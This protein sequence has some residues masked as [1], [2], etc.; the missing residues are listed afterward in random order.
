MN[1]LLAF[2][3][4]F[5]VVGDPDEVSQAAVMRALHRASAK[6]AAEFGDS[7]EVAIDF[8]RDISIRMPLLF[9]RVTEQD[10][11]ARFSDLRQVRRDYT[12]LKIIY[13]HI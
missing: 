10:V 5:P 9:D 1:E 12:W 7:D 4:S 3:Y 11:L 8:Y 2:N 6:Y 13:P